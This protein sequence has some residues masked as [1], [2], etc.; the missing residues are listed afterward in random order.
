MILSE[1]H[2]PPFCESSLPSTSLFLIAN[3]ECNWQWIGNSECNWQWIGNWGM[4]LAMAHT[5]LAVVFVLYHA[6]I[7][8]GAM[9]K[10][11]NQLPISR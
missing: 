11:W 4:K 10:Y 8:N 6:R 1:F 9:N 3:S 5:A 2:L 7:G